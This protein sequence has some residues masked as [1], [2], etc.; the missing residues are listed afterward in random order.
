MNELER[1]DKYT[2]KEMDNEEVFEPL[3]VH[4]ET[5][6]VDIGLLYET[7]LQTF[8]MDEIPELK[9]SIQVYGLLTPLTVCMDE[10][11]RYEVLSGNQRA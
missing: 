4:S 2:V 6:N 10:N 3:F 11:G 9:Q 7:P 1:T 8:E 5:K